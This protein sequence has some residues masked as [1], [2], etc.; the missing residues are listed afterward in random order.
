M[1]VDF[2]ERAGPMFAA[3]T[4]NREWESGGGSKRD[5]RRRSQRE[6]RS[7]HRRFSLQCAKAPGRI[8]QARRGLIATDRYDWA[9]TSYGA[10]GIT[11]P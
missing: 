4:Q 8:G 7:A 5:A 2:G 11:Q 6:E 3:G 1:R 10:T 9:C